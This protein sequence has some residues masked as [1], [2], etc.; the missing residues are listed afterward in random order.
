MT[1]IMKMS[2]RKVA[3]LALASVGLLVP[4]AQAA[5][6]STDVD[7]LIL[8]FYATTPGSTG[9]T[10]NLEVDLGVMSTFLTATAG[11]ITAIPSLN[12]QDLIDTY[13]ANWGSRADLFW[14][15]VA[16]TGRVTGY[17]AKP[18]GT[19]WA[20]GPDCASAFNRFSSSA[21]FVAS[22]NIE[23]LYSG[24]PG[25]LGGA[26]AT[27][28]SASAASI[29]AALAGSWSDA[30]AGTPSFGIFSP[31]VDNVMDVT[32]NYVVSQVYEMQPNSSFGT[33]GT[34]VGDLILC[35]K[36][37]VTLPGGIAIPQGLSFRAASATAAVCTNITVAADGT[38]HATVTTTQVG[39]GSTG[40][41]LGEDTFGST[42]AV[43]LPIGTSNLTYT[44]T[45][46]FGTTVHCTA[47]VTVR[48][49]AP[50]IS[51][52]GSINQCSTTVT[53]SPA[54]AV[55]SGCNTP[56][57]AV[58]CVPISGST[59][60][61]GVTTVTC[62]AIDAASLTGT[63]SFAVTI[64]GAAPTFTAPANIVTNAALGG[65]SVAVSYTTPTG[66]GCAT[67][68]N[69]VCVP[70]SGSTF[71]VGTSNVV[72][73][74][75]DALNQTTTHSFTVTV[76]GAGISGITSL[77]IGDSNAVNV[78]TLGY[79]DHTNTFTAAR[80]NSLLSSLNLASRQLSLAATN[81]LKTSRNPAVQAAYRRISTA[82]SNAACSQLTG[83]VLKVQSLE[84][85]GILSSN[86]AT[87]LL[88]AAAGEKAAIGCP[89]ATD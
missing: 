79:K 69:V 77:V 30:E 3:L 28:N 73:T 76:N 32:T 87:A 26:A 88:G 50:V 46:G 72:C 83:F 5:P 2:H 63:V 4:L 14:G 40:Y 12:V 43:V 7:H 75:T 45:D 22:A 82:E 44:V 23:A 56:I 80:M 8:G 11:S 84:R 33:F 41:C 9:A 20:S 71:N 24:A 38:C 60:T 55:T 53:Y 21:Q 65:T 78:V 34:Y 62:T 54:P 48:G 49:A 67:P 81:A 42:N 25:S 51:N 57:G 70:N 36:A 16:T 27:A 29:T 39:G 66:S 58:T 6:V 47:A 19:L 37:G 89:G 52:P 17:G 13:G 61:A 68:I 18:V 15:A 59:F 10:K 35:P 31:T 1:K 74:A 64:S 85:S 86:N